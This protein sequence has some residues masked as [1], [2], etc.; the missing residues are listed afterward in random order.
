MIVSDDET[1]W[2]DGTSWEPSIAIDNNGN[3]YAVWQDTTDGI[4]GTDTEIM[5]AYNDGNG[6]S[7]ATVIS[8]GFNNEYWNVASSYSPEIAI[9][10][11]GNL[12]VV[13]EDW[14]IGPWGTDSEIMYTYNDGS[15]WSNAT[16]IS[17]DM[18]NWN[19][20][21]SNNP[22]IAVDDNGVIYVTW[23]DDTEGIWWGG[24]GDSE[25]MYT[26]ND[27]SGWSNV[28]IISDG[29]SN[30]Y[31]NDDSSYYPKIA[32]DN[33]EIKYIVWV[34]DTNGIWG[35]DT[36][37]MYAYND[38]SGWS[39]VTVISDDMSNWNNGVSSNPDIVVDDN[40]TLY[41]VWEDNTNGIWG[42]G[43]TDYEIMYVF[44]NG[45]GWSN[46]TVIS[47]GFNNEYWNNGDSQN[48]SIAINNDD[49]TIHVVWEDGT[50]G[51]WETDIE[52]MY[53]YNDGS[54]WSNATLVSDG[55]KYTL[56]YTIY[57]NT[58]NSRRPDIALDDN[59][60]I[61]VVWDDTTQLTWGLDVDILYLSLSFRDISSSSIPFG[62]SYLFFMVIG[63]SG[64]FIQ[65][66]RKCKQKLLRTYN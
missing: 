59:G 43:A 32:V 22:S 25:I 36:E 60:I 14:T 50:D 44:N 6:W 9:D 41:V 26:Y 38:G 13:W 45:T 5:Y 29:Y 28:A 57:W 17:D 51:I 53:A 33:N 39:N 62:N 49:G 10:N 64:I 7:K 12:H 65:I 55:Y 20:G 3:L 46:I 42:G 31:W 47:D 61:H 58:G 37:I 11:N 1:R 8:D 48:P 21:N 23:Y 54:G 52:I 35:T 4:W 30:E 27:G 19:D 15:G 56:D 63:F 34:D 66:L 40:E 18:S 16:V 24:S 2:N